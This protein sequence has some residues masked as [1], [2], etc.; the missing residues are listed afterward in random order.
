MKLRKDRNRKTTMKPLSDERGSTIVLVA[1]AMTALMSVV[2]L[3][4]DVGMLF[5][6]RSEAQRAADAAALAGAG[7]LIF[8]DP[9]DQETEERARTVAI[10]YGDMNTVRNAQADVLPEDVEVD[11]A[12]GR[13]TVTVRRIAERG[14][15][16]GTWFATVFDVNEVDVAARAT[17]AI[18]SAGSA[19]CVKPFAIPDRFW[20][21]NGNGTFDGNDEYDPEVHGY[22]SPWRNS[23]SPGD[24]GQGYTN[25]F[26]REVKLKQGGPDSHQP[27]WYYPWDMPQ[28]DGEPTEGADRYRWNI[29]N[30]NPAIVSVGEEYN[31]E[32]GVMHGPT[33]QGS[34]DLIVQDPSAYWDVSDN[35][36][37]GSAWD[38]AWMDSPRI[39]LV[40]VFHPGRP[41]E[42]GKKPIEFTNFIA[43]FFEGVEGSGSDQEVVGRIMYASGIAGGE[44][45]APGAKFVRL[46]E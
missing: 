26:G 14:N 46:V 24:D 40:P 41:F 12:G 45:G 7:E 15:A 18:E 6:A 20:D 34:N 9:G 23:G 4:V 16:V 43:M 35:V 19:K 8:A 44:V 13:V 3:A 22:G 28:A 25:D 31:V 39:V 11:V 32:N 42:P 2:A 30:C 37:A 27:S 38:P 10:E 29:A 1:L 36:V 5:T 21:K 17:A 33:E